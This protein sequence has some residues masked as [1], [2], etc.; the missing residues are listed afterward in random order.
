M[1]PDSSYFS[2][3]TFT[4]TYKGNQTNTCS[5]RQSTRKYQDEVETGFFSR[6]SLLYLIK[7]PHGPTKRTLCPELRTFSKVVL[8][9][10]GQLDDKVG[11]L[12]RGT[13][14]PTDTKIFL[15][16]SWISRACA[17]LEC[18]CEFYRQEEERRV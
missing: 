6:V 5:L 18:C 15:N 4:C 1:K 2:T 8:I 12:T 7:A 11:T 14:N 3:A 10:L 16:K 17:F 13:H 9:A